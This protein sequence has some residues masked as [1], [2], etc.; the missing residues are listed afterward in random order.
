MTHCLGYDSGVHAADEETGDDWWYS[1]SPRH[2]D[3]T[4][5]RWSEWHLRRRALIRDR[6]ASERFM[7]QLGALIRSGLCLRPECD[8]LWRP[9]PGSL[10]EAGPWGLASIPSR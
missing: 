10:R 9:C 3:T 7:E 1:L 5:A 4:K 6:P 2:K 8:A